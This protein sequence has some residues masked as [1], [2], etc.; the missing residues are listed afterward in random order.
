MQKL[1]LILIIH[2]SLLI[3]NCFSQ[4]S[5]TWQRIYD[6]PL[7]ND[8]AGRDICPANDGNF[9][10][11]GSTPIIGLGSEI[12]VLKIN[13]YG[14]TIWSKIIGGNDGNQTGDAITSSSDGGCVLTG[15]FDSSF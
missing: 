10:I 1:A 8:D 5:I 2:Y 6:G 3:T 4:P 14:D 12:Y 7:H 15:G 13:A 9:F 11:V